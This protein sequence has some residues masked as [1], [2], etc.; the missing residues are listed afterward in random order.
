MFN[1]LFTI[2]YIILGLPPPFAFV[3]FNI[4]RERQAYAKSNAFCGLD[5]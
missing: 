3:N 1:F 5:M 4:L 2:N